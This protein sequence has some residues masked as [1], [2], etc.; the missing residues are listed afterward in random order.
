M[1]VLVAILLLLAS[2]AFAQFNVPGLSSDSAAYQS[3]LVAPFP[4][5]GAPQ[6]RRQAEQ[7]AADAQRRNDWAGVAAA[8]ETR[9]GAGSET[10]EQW[11]ALARAHLRRT[12]PEASRAAWAAWRAFSGADAGPGVNPVPAGHGG[13]VP[14]HGPA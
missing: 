12:P 5:G 4:A 3:R 14:H 8:L 10:N 7:R 2:P 6:A 13:G 1:R 11:L 9:V